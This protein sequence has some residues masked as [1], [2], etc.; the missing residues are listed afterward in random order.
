MIGSQSD[1]VSGDVSVLPGV[2]TVLSAVDLDTSP[3]R[4]QFYVTRPPRHGRLD[5][6]QRSVTAA[7]VN[8]RGLSVVSG[9]P[10]GWAG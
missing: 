7:A 6:Q 5:V 10:M 2:D 4:L 1:D 3:D 8:R 9:V